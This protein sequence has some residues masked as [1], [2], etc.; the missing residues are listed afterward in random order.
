MAID[1]LIV[2]TPKMRLTGY[3][4]L[5]L[6]WCAN[7]LAE[8]SFTVADIQVKG[9]QRVS[10]ATVFTELGI[11]VG[12]VVTPSQLQQASRALF[13]TG[14][15]A[16]IQLGRDGDVLVVVI[17]ERPVILGL[18]IAGNKIIPEEQLLSVLNDNGIAEGQILKQATLT[19]IIRDLQNQYAAQGRYAAQIVVSVDELPRNQ[20]AVSIDI[21]EGQVAKIKH[22]NIVGNQIFDDKELKELFQLETSGWWSWVDGNDKYAK[23]KLAGDL[24]RLKSFYLD[25]GY[26]QFNID[27]TQVSLSPDKQT[28]FITVNITEGR[29]FTVGEIVLAGNLVIDESPMRRLILFREGQIFSQLLMASTQDAMSKRLGDEGYSFAKVRAVTDL[30]KDEK[31][32]KMTFFID[33]GQRTYVRRINFRGNQ[34]TADHVLRREMRQMEGAPFSA[35]KLELSKLRLERLGFFSRVEMQTRK[36]PATNDQVD[37]E[38]SIEEQPS[39]N[40]NA[41]IGFSQDSGINLGVGVE[42]DNWFGTGNRVGFNIRSSKSQKSYNFNYI[43]PYF[44][45]DGVSR[46]INL[47]FLERDFDELDISNYTTDTF[48]ARVTFGY[49]ISEVSRVSMGFSF[50]NIQIETGVTAVQEIIGSPRQR[51]RVAKKYTVLDYDDY[52]DRTLENFDRVDDNNNDYLDEGDNYI[53][54][55]PVETG[56]LLPLTDNQLVASPN[57]FIDDNGD[58]FDT[59]KLTLGWSNSTLNRGIFATRGYSQSVNF[60]ATLPASDI[61]FYKLTYTGQWFQPLTERLTLRLRSKLGYGSG[62]GATNRFPFFENF[63]S[64][65]IGSVRGFRPNSLGP[66]S[67]RGSAYPAVPIFRQNGDK[68]RDGNVDSDDELE[69]IYVAD[70]GDPTKL[71]TFDETDIN[72]FGGNMLFEAGVEIIFPLPFIKEQRSV[73]S[74]LFID[75]GNV[76]D[77]QCGHLQQNCD[78][79]NLSNLSISAGLGIQWLSGFGPL[80]FSLAKPIK[81]Q[82]FDR[83]QAFEFSLGRIF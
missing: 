66:K 60:E 51:A 47:F 55:K 14:L 26:L 70:T 22:I 69:F 29:V 15:F 75:S 6:L 78:D 10:A 63:F 53:G 72:T 52:R 12:K 30:N 20:V 37:I 8:A 27:S 58:T 34:R 48:G 42:Q 21:D 62:Y 36:V 13:G 32:V 39:G 68:N 28:V 24:Q 59:F 45:A 7:V 23:E 76:F 11:D 67:S 56:Q 44:T 80:T 9:L 57:G 4:L 41:S 82:P 83:T 3:C 19:A 38:F 81:K 31:T 71:L 73:R 65:G 79:F 74:S 5:L 16:D 54:E 50:E 43:D 46:G 33:P 49:P 40:V 2:I 61:E 1:S 17:E 64:G 18:S 25:R 77:S 35:S